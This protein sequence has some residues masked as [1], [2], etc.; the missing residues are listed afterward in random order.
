MRMTDG[1]VGFIRQ[2][3]DLPFSGA[4]DWLCRDK[5]LD[6][7]GDRELCSATDSNVIFD[8]GLSRDAV[9]MA[10]AILD[11][12]RLSVR[13]LTTVLEVLVIYG[14]DGSRMIELPLVQ[15]PP[16]GGYRKPHWL[17]GLVQVNPKNE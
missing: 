16:K 13:P 11:D 6:P 1:L 15:K 12:S 8:A 14:Y 3:G 7:S 2:H 10:R 5:G 17:A 9:R 4:V